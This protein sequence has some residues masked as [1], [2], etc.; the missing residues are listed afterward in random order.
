MIATGK[1]SVN[2]HNVV[3]NCHEEVMHHK[4]NFAYHYGSDGISATSNMDGF[5]VLN[6]IK[7]HFGWDTDELRKAAHE[8]NER[9]EVAILGNLN[10]VLLLVPRTRVQDTEKSRFYINDLLNAATAVKIRKLQFTHYSFMNRLGF[11]G[12]VVEVLRALLDPN[13]E[14]SINE[15]VLDTDYRLVSEMN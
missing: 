5:T 10:P 12:E 1:L 9:D 13:L 14:T 6:A 7:M 4:I 3:H 15:F 2:L 8:C 11:T